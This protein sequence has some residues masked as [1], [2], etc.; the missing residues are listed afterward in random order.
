M[1]LIQDELERV[2]RALRQA[3]PPERFAQLY[4]AQ[5]ALAWARE[6]SGFASPTETIA[7]GAVWPSAR[8]DTQAALEDCSRQS[9]LLAS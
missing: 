1:S 4:V 6:P 7:R 9:D 2:G 8:L 3:P 5:Q